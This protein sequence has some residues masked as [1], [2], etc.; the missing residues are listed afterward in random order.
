VLVHRNNWL[1]SLDE[2]LAMRRKIRDSVG[3]KP[4]NEIKSADIKKGRG[5]LFE[6]RWSPERRLVFF[7]NVLKYVA[8]NLTDL[9]I[10]SAV[11]DKAESHARGNEPRETAWR[12]A[13]QRVHRYCSDGDT[14]A[15]IFPDEGHGVLV[16]R[17]IRKMRRYERVPSRFGGSSITVPIEQIIEDPNDRQSHD[18]YFIQLADWCANAA[19]R[20]KY[21][22][23]QEGV[24]DDLWD[25]LGDRRLLKVNRLSGGPPGIKYY[26]WNEGT[27]TF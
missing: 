21:V 17:L 9:T 13:L 19:H 2:L 14:G 12:Y 20:S 27:T 23:P 4:R 25:E 24:P 11:I 7:R 8:T 1:K 15:M 3:I 26:P 22:D 6:L 5:P 18:S 10:F 16:K